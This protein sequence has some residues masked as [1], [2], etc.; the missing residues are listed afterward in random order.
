MRWF[1]RWFFLDKVGWMEF[2][3]FRRRVRS[4]QTRNHERVKY[5]AKVLSKQLGDKVH[6]TFE[7]K[8]ALLECNNFVIARIAVFVKTEEHPIA[9]VEVQTD[10]SR[11]YLAWFQLAFLGMKVDMKPFE[12]KPV[13]M[14]GPPREQ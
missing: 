3:P 11:H 2:W 13:L 9:E 12:K 7:R 8:H 4:H 10:L 6:C 14:L 5:L 1:Y